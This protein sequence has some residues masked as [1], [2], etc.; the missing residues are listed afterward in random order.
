MISK[1]IENRLEILT[2]E[3]DHLKVSIAPALGGKI[4]S[5]FNKQLQKEFLW[6]NAHLALQMNAPGADY[7]FNFFGAIDELLPNDTPETVDG[8]SYPD[9][10]E[11]WTTALQYLEEDGKIILSGRLELSGLHYS[12]IVFLD[13]KKPVIFVDYKITNETAEQRSFLWKLHAALRIEP[14]DQLVTAAK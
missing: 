6:T 7:D 10:G 14:G 5:V 12:K 4:T 3:N 1:H 11:L 13:A 9:H 8:I 2:I